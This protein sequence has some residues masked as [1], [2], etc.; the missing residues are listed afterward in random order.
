VIRAVRESFFGGRVVKEVS[1]TSLTP[2]AAGDGRGH[3]TLV[4]GLAAAM[5]GNWGGASPTSKLVS[6]DVLNDK[7]QGLTSDVIAAADWIYQHKDEYGIR[8]AN[9][10]LHAE[11]K[12]SFLEDPLDRAVEQLWLSGVVVVTASGNYGLDGRASGVLY[13]PAN[14][15]FVITVGA[16]DVHGTQDLA[17]D[18]ASPWSAYGFTLDG[19]SK[20]ELGAPGRYMIGAVPTTATMPL[21]RPDRIVAPGFMWMSRH[22]VRR[23]RRRRCGRG[24]ARAAP[25]LDP[26]SGQGCPDVFGE[27]AAVRDAGERR[28]RRAQARRRRAHHCAAQ[29]KSGAR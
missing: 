9:F 18:Y 12:S 6:L 22:V 16:L 19:F 15:P 17:D 28:S 11:G 13:A 24:S 25:E 27:G 10:S 29:S 3:G 5:S 23:S 21:E 7:G 1:L 2:N 26:G 8:V 14:D 20:P 4:A